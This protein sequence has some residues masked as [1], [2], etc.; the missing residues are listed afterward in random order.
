MT[1]YSKMASNET[2]S[3][4]I[5]KVQEMAF[6]NN[7]SC[8]TIFGVSVLQH[9]DFFCG[10]IVMIMERMNLYSHPIIS[11]APPSFC[12]V[13]GHQSLHEAAAWG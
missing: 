5:I 13:A 9:Q 2:F 1:S 7:A 8:N 10:I 12:N 6:S 3:S 4:T 11:Y